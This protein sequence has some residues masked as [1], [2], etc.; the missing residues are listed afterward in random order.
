MTTAT[1]AIN[2]AT[3][4]MTAAKKEVNNIKRQQEQTQIQNN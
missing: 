4:A 1:T 3:N 2:N